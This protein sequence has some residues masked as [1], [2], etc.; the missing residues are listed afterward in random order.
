M[1]LTNISPY[2]GIEVR[3]LNLAKPCEVQTTESLLNHFHNHH[4]LIIKNQKLTEDH[5]IGVSHVFGEPVQA[6]VPSQDRM[7]GYRINRTPGPIFLKLGRAVRY[8]KQDL[9]D[10]L[11]Q[12]RKVRTFA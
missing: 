5:L 8:R 2:L 3:N 4:L 9:D 7:N 12:H 1:Q 10:W 6:L 11:D